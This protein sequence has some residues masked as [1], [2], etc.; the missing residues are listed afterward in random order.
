V[1]V[2]IGVMKGVRHVEHM[3]QDNHILVFICLKNHA[4]MTHTGGK[5]ER[6]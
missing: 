2:N 6:F 3:K 4:H 1:W 5:C